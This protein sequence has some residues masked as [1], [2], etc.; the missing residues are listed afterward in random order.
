[1]KRRGCG[2]G[3]WR[4]EGGRREERG[5][6]GRGRGVRGGG[7]R[8]GGEAGE[9]CEQAGKLDPEQQEKRKKNDNASC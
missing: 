3:G 1:M 2:G 6:A 8:G 7:R 5:R 9:E 4:G